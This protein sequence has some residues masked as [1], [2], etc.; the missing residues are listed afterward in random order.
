[1]KVLRVLTGRGPG[2]DNTQEGEYF[3]AQMPGRICKRGDDPLTFIRM[4]WE[5]NALKSSFCAKTKPTLVGMC[6]EAYSGGP[7]QLQGRH[8]RCSRPGH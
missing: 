2:R 1:M 6:G 4:N 3:S 5:E 7:I 8:E